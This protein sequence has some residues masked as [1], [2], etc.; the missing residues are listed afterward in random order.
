MLYAMD[1]GPGQLA[2]VKLDPNTGTLTKTWG[3][4]DQRT[5]SFTTLI[6]P[7]DERVLVGTNIKVT[8][9]DQLKDSTYTEQWVWRNADTGA[10]LARSE[11]FDAMTVGILP[12]PGYGGLMYDLQQYGGIVATQVLPASRVPGSAKSSS[13]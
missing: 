11:Y 5:F 10:V 9:P 7:K 8:N 13:G 12:T 2:A 1:F 6:G 3:P 4:V